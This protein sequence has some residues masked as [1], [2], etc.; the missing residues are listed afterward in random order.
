MAHNKN[1]NLL[2]YLRINC[3]SARSAPELLSLKNEYTLRFLNFV[4]LGLC[5]TPANCWSD[6]FSFL[7]VD[8]S[9]IDEVSD[10]VM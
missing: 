8:L 4:I 1:Q 3:I 2:L 6:K 10:R 9:C 5:N 7:M